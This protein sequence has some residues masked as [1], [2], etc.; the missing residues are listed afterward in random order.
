MLLQNEP[1]SVLIVKVVVDE[2]KEDAIALIVMMEGEAEDETIM[3]DNA[4]RNHEINATIIL[5]DVAAVIAVLET[6][7][8][9]A[10]EERMIE[11]VVV[12][13]I[14]SMT[15]GEDEDPVMT[16]MNDV[17]RILIKMVDRPM[18][19]VVVD[20]RPWLL[21]MIKDEGEEMIVEEGTH[22]TIAWPTLD[23]A[24]SVV[25]EA[26]FLTNAETII[27]KAAE[28]AVTGTRRAEEEEGRRKTVVVAVTTLNKDLSMDMLIEV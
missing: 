14:E 11:E 19:A 6:L 21:L 26:T 2:T 24:I 9:A 1:E 8:V 20:F 4:T 17:G 18:I 3:D 15:I 10:V 7:W 28:E 12:A 27:D 13:G 16:T 22:Q 25:V 23:E 5:E